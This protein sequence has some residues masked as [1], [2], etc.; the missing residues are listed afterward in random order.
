[1]NTDAT[2]YRKAF[3]NYLRYGISLEVQLKA[4]EEQ[5]PRFYIW[6]TQ[7]DDKVRASHAARHGQIFSYDDP[8]ISPPGTFRNLALRSTD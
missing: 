6:V 2:V 7:G 3:Q 8:N 4:A 1:M 5:T